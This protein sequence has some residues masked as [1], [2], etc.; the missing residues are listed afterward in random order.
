MSST[1]S[2]DKINAMAAVLASVKEVFIKNRDKKDEIIELASSILLK[3][4]QKIN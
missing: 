3:E 1:E 4:L 2:V